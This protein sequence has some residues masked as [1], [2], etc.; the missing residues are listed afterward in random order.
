MITAGVAGTRRLLPEAGETSGVLRA[1]DSATEEL[2]TEQS[3]LANRAPPLLAVFVIPD[4]LLLEAVA[5][6]GVAAFM[7][8]SPETA[9]QGIVAGAIHRAGRICV[10]WRYGAVQ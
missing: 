10:R 1:P 7:H 5:K 2:G 8:A 4:P 9:T 3:S 6:N